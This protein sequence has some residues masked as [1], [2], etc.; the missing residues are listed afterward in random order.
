MKH[1]VAHSP[2][3]LQSTIYHCQMPKDTVR[4]QF[5]H[6]LSKSY[7]GKQSEFSRDVVDVRR[8]PSVLKRV[9]LHK[10]MPI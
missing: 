4:G 9:V 3:S 8:F 2:S 1:L 7:N 5:V 10:C 6:W